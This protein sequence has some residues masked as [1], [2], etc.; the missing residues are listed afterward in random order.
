MRC[1]SAGCRSSG[2][3]RVVLLERAGRIL[4]PEALRG[5]GLTP[6]E[7]AVLYGFARGM[8]PAAVAAELGISPRTVAKHTQRIHAKL[9]VRNRAQ[10]VATAWAAAGGG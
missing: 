3:G 1:W 2:T 9:G 10:A 8:E 5:L 7:A 6:R 4:S